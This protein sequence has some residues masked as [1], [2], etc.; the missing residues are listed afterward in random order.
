MIV[1][2]MMALVGTLAVTMV[3]R[4]RRGETSPAFARNLY[5][6]LMQARQ[7]AVALRRPTRVTISPTTKRV[8]AEI[9]DQDIN[10][11]A[12]WSPLGSLVMPSESEICE[13]DY[14]ATV[15]TLSTPT[16]PAAGVRVINF[17]TEKPV[18]VTDSAGSLLCP[19]SSNGTCAALSIP[20]HTT[21][22]VKH[23][24]IFLY[25]L[26]GQPRLSDAW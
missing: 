21:D 18:T 6:Q 2:A 10:S 19:T 4:V 14:T 20:I 13:L 22:D 16:C 3:S 8:I 24:K 23:Y 17:A 9:R 1:V 7:A 5:V 11:A 25:G 26:T 15:G 12:T